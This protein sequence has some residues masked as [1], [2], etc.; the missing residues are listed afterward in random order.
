MP[1]ATQR[2]AARDSVSR[3]VLRREDRGRAMT[4]QFLGLGSFS[5]DPALEILCW[6]LQAPLGRGTTFW[7]QILGQLSYACNVSP[8]L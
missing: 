5:M 2:G 8:E 4:G 6:A 1:S 7:A 3:A